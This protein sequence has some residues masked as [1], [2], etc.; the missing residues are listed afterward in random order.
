MYQCLLLVGICEANWSQFILTLE[1]ADMI[2]VT[3]PNQTEV[4]QMVLCIFSLLHWKINRDKI[5]SYFSSVSLWKFEFSKDSVNTKTCILFKPLELHK[6]IRKIC[7]LCRFYTSSTKWIFNEFEVFT[8]AAVMESN[9]VLNFRFYICHLLVLQVFVWGFLLP[10]RNDCV[11]RAISLIFKY[12]YYVFLCNLT[13]L[14][15]IFLIWTQFLLF[16]FFGRIHSCYLL[17]DSFYSCLACF[18]S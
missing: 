7:S 9:R 6:S 13:D 1:L 17:S 15:L 11:F 12:A 8:Q 2:K 3:T 4:V 10:K 14:G 5:S 16:F 18:C